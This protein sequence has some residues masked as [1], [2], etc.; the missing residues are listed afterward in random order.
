M[1]HRRTLQPESRRSLG[2]NRA[3]AGDHRGAAT[4][5]Q[6]RAGCQTAA[7]RHGQ[8]DIVG[9]ERPIERAVYREHPA[10]RS[11]TRFDAPGGCRAGRQGG[12]R[13]SRVGAR[14]VH[15][16]DPA[17]G[18]VKVEGVCQVRGRAPSGG[19]DAG[20]RRE[21]V[22]RQRRAGA[23]RQRRGVRRGDC[24]RLVTSEYGDG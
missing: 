2:A 5:V 10:A 9:P 20:A 21:T 22:R 4:G 18:G 1:F 15:T 7:G 13:A 16:H 8:R 19:C 3:S 12:V 23:V 17:F 24:R 11:V 6:C 14:R